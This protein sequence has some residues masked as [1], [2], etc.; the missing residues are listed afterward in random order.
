MDAFVIQGKAHL[1]GSVLVNGSKNAALPQMAAALLTA[2]PVTITD[3][4]RLSD[5]ASMGQLLEELGCDVEEA[6][7]ASPNTGG[8]KNGY[9]GTAEPAS[10]R[11]VG[12]RLRIQTVDETATHARYEI[13]RT[14]R[15]SISVL[16]PL[17]ARRGVARVSMP[18]GCAIGDRPVDL[19]LRG[20]VAMGADINLCSGDITATAPV[21]AGGRRRLKGARIFLGG[22]FGSTVLGTA[23][24][25]SAA[26][27]AEGTTVIENAACEPEV[28]DLGRMLTAMGA[29]I[30]GAGTPRIVIEGVEELGGVDHRVM[31][32]RIE[33]GTFMMI[34]AIT[35]SQITIENCPLDALMAV[36]D[37]LER[38]GVKI[39]VREPGWVDPMRVR[40]DVTCDRTLNPVEM[41]TQPY[42]GFPTDL[43]AQLLALLTIAEG[44]SVVTEKIFPER[45]LHVAELTR[46]GASAF[47]Q[48]P[49]VV[50]SGVRRLVGAPVMASDLRASACLVMAG[51]A[52]EGETIVRRVYHL[53]R[54]YERMDLALRDM[55]AEIERIDDRDLERR[56]EEAVAASTARIHS[57]LAG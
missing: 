46:M 47:R 35:N 5:L 31:P 33:A 54:G 23:N 12:R 21:G 37:R 24:I 44:N 27:L 49:T 7:R 57:A 42:P 13:V 17:L 10:H 11:S 43:Q 15:A 9:A 40:C 16:G 4:P 1:S 8:V 45:F 22:P 39:T 6:G 19:H 32:D 55:G 52:A 28:Q 30:E 20:L 36:T 26:T 38:I 29:R 25:M 14:M 50:V 51:L 41:T 56:E 34:G 53:D 48:G 2:E 3:A 18:G